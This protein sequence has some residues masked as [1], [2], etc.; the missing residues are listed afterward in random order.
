MVTYLWQAWHREVLLKVCLV[1]VIGAKPPRTAH[2]H[3]CLVPMYMKLCKRSICQERPQAHSAWTHIELVRLG[4]LQTH[5]NRDPCTVH[6]LLLKWR[7]SFNHIESSK[8]FR[9]V[10]NSIASITIALGFFPLVWANSHYCKTLNGLYYP[11]LP[12]YIYIYRRY[13]S[14]I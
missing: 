9:E 10:S 11:Y 12:I 3:F 8:V 7:R 14:L 4:Y 6:D 13:T 1:S 2:L 5:H